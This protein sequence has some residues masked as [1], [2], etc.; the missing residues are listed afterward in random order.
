MSV[1]RRPWHCE[2]HDLASDE[3]PELHTQPRLAWQLE[4]HDLVGEEVFAQPM[5]VLLLRTGGDGGQSRVAQGGWQKK[6]CMICMNRTPIPQ[7]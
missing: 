5:V 3:L 6:G 7:Q 2:L 4:W 1:R